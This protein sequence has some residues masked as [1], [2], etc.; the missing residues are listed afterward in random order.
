MP[1]ECILHSAHSSLRADGRA[2]AHKRF[3]RP[4]AK[5]SPSPRHLLR[6][7]RV[8]CAP[9]IIQGQLQPDRRG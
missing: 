8:T 7:R 1:E 5:K 4:P 2:K 3:E 9:E 6:G